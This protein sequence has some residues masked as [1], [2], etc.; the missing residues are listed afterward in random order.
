MLYNSYSMHNCINIK[1]QLNRDSTLH[2]P[3]IMFTLLHFHNTHVLDF[4]STR[5]IHYTSHSGK[6]N[7]VGIS[8]EIETT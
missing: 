1:F 2:P 4:K 8:N 6:V 5:L 7:W 3:S